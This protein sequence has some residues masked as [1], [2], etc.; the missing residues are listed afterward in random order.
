MRSRPAE[1]P[2]PVLNEY[3]K[4][5]LNC[6]FSIHIS[7]QS[8]EDEF[9]F[10]LIEYDLKSD[11]LAKMISDG[12]AE[13]LCRVVCN[14]TSFR[15]V[16]PFINKRAE[17]RVLKK[18]LSD[19]LAIDAN[20]IVSKDDVI[21]RN[22]DFNPNYFGPLSFK[23]RKG[24]ILANEP[25]LRVKLNTI[26]EKELPSIIQI[27]RDSTIDSVQVHYAKNGETDPQYS[28]YIL[29][30]LPEKEYDNYVN[31]R[32][33]Q[34]L[35]FGIERFLQCSL[36]FPVLVEAICLLKNDMQSDP[37]DQFEHYQETIW[38]NTI[39]AVLKKN[40]IEDLETCQKTN[41]ELANIILNNV[42]SDSMSNLLKKLNDWNKSNYQAD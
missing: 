2:Y 5:Y 40:E 4:D 26:L 21:Y 11:G 24:D 39:I 20:V 35:K 31:M 13:V 3:S 7:E 32:L 33:K 28:D 14:R 17:I 15:M 34:Y 16:F 25:G 22:D 29:V 36:I 38:A 12:N 8:D 27:C 6:S 23:V 30:K 9:L 19:T 18:C 10:L 41:F 37:T 42:V 1:Y